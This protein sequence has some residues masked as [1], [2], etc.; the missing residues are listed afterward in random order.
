MQCGYEYENII[1][2]FNG[3]IHIIS[4]CVC[5]QQLCNQLRR[6]GSEKYGAHFKWNAKISIWK[7]FS[8]LR[9]IFLKIL[10]L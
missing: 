8:V 4:T 2:L 7:K 3:P 10:G 6:Q 9:I 1:G 5:N